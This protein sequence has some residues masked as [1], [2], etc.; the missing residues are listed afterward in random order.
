MQYSRFAHP[1]C[2]GKPQP[3]PPDGHS[4]SLPEVQ[5][6]S[7]V[8]C[9][10]QISQGEHSLKHDFTGVHGLQSVSSSRWAESQLPMPPEVE[11][12]QTKRPERAG[13]SQHPKQSQPLGVKG[14][15]ASRQ[16]ADCCAKSSAQVAAVPGIDVAGS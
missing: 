8:V 6:A 4:A 16:A 10:A 3:R 7:M 14:R 5:L 9:P 13:N 1:A 2:P 12:I 15:H 11:P